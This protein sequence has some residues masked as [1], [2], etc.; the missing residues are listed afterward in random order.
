MTEKIITA[1]LMAIL[2]IPLGIYKGFLLGI[3]FYL[4]KWYFTQS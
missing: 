4:A 1:I 3:G 2:S